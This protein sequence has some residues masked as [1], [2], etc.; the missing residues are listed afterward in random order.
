M[1]RYSTLIISLGLLP[2]N[3]NAGWYGALNLGI[4]AVNVEKNLTYPIGDP[5]ATSENFHSGYT[6]FH[7]QLAAGYGF[8]LTNQIGLNIEGN[9]DLFTGEAE[10]TIKNWFF[11]EPVQTEEKLKYGFSLFALPEYHYNEY[12]RFFAGP[13]VSWS[14]FAISYENTAGNVGVTG[15]FDEWLTGWALK[16]G[17]ANQL[18]PCTESFYL[19]VYSIRQCHLD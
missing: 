6:N 1:N 16:A 10:H 18:T 3:V 13:G 15:H 7:G 11:S 5:F 19:P 4:N 12:V 14:K 9:A 17:V 8:L 2:F